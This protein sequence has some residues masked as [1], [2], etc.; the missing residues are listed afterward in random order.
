MKIKRMVKRLFAVGTGVAM[1]GAT[2][3][4]AMAAVDL[5]DYPN[6]F[7]KDGVFD[8]YFVVG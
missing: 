3:M 5:K 1:L 2:A 4:G 6:M 8:G 7:V